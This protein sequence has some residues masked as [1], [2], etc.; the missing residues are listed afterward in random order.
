MRKPVWLLWLWILIVVCLVCAGNAGAWWNEQWQ[1]RKKV[2]FDSSPTGADIKSNLS[3][4][5]VLVKL[6]S[7]N[8]NFANGSD[9]GED[10]R[11]VAADDQK[12]LKHHIEK[13]DPIDE[14]GYIWVRLPKLSG[15]VSTDYIWMY[16]GNREAVGGQDGAGTFDAAHVA[17]FHLSELEGAPED[18][19]AYNNHVGVFQGGQGLPSVIGNGVTLSGAGDKLQIPASPSL[20]FTQGFTFSAWI[21]FQQP[22]TAATVF[23]RQEADGSGIFIRIEETRAC[24][25]IV[26]PDGRVFRTDECMDLSIGSWHHVAFSAQPN[27]RMSTYLDGLELFYLNLPVSLPQL[28]GDLFVGDS[29]EGGNAFVGDLDEIRIANTARPYDWIRASFK[30]QGPDDS[31]AQVGIEEIGGGSSG[32]PVF[33][34]ATVLKNITLD[35]WCVIGCLI[36]LGVASW[37]VILTKA[38]LLFSVEKENRAFKESYQEIP[39]PV[40]FQENG[41]HYDQSTLFRVFASGFEALK[42]CLEKSGHTPETPKKDGVLDSRA[43]KSVKAAL[44]KGFIEESQRLN[45]WLVVL[46]MGISGGPFLGLLGTVWGV[47]NTFAAMAEAGEANIMAIAPGVASALSTTVIGL[48]VAIPALF[49][50]N[51]LTGKIKSIT[52]EMMIIVDQL[53]I[54]IEEIYGTHS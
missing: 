21:R 27:G 16:Y 49:G 41:D 47:M 38:A 48:I 40:D 51:Y 25:Q 39:D 3:E 50:Y 29:P 31:L 13:Y 36:I 11:F 6:H 42:H 20:D 5:P 15:G 19:T 18:A 30:S 9:T 14:I 53:S 12:L 22:Q 33:Y 54:N 23:S 7:G 52:A 32:L 43:T 1:Y 4:I 35:G 46:T 2:G 10:I 24:F 28:S 44:E 37:V 17:V 8:Y 34:L 26:T 45:S